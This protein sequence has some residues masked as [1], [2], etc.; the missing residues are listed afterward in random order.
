[1]GMRPLKSMEPRSMPM[2]HMMS[3]VEPMRPKRSQMACSI[4][5][6]LKPSRSAMRKDTAVANKMPN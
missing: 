6:Q 3:M 1:M 5:S 2:S 4:S